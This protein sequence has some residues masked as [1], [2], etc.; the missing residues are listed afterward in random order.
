MEEKDAKSDEP[1]I[2]IDQ[3]QFAHGHAADFLNHIRQWVHWKV[4]VPR[5]VEPTMIEK[6]G[7]PAADTSEA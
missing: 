5:K 7:V 4:N 2:D 3:F 6:P 1:Q